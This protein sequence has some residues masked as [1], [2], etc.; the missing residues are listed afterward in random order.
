MKRKKFHKLPYTP[1]SKKKKEILTKYAPDFTKLQ[2]KYSA[3]I[4]KEWVG[5]W[6]AEKNII[7]IHKDLDIVD[8]YGVIIHEFIEMMVTSLMG[9]PGYPHPDYD[10]EIHGERNL[11]AHNFANSVEK[12]I[13]EMANVEWDAHEERVLKVRN[14][15]NKKKKTK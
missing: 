3:R 9:I 14:N 10:Q 15:K 11:T 1:R 12:R 5:D 13:L 8:K 4:Q 7:K 2:I 6:N